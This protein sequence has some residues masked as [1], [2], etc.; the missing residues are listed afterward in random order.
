MLDYTVAATL[1][2][3]LE[4]I[5][6]KA[7]NTEGKPPLHIA[8]SKP[9]ASSSWRR[10][11]RPPPCSRRLPL[12]ISVCHPHLHRHLPS[13]GPTTY[14]HRLFDLRRHDH[15]WTSPSGGHS[16]Q[17]PPTGEH[18]PR[19]L[20]HELRLLRDLMEQALQHYALLE[21]VTNDAPS[22]DPGWIRMDSIILNWINNSISADLHKVVQERGCTAVARRATVGSLLSNGSMPH[23]PRLCVA[24][25]APY[26]CCQPPWDPHRHHR[27]TQSV[28]PAGPL[29]FGQVRLPS[30]VLVPSTAP[31]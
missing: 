23:T 11:P 18:H 26:G 27:L 4:A 10:C 29:I 17:C 31:Y 25:G 2:A 15:R 22:T 1:R 24:A 9:P 14:P 30:T 20:L 28:S 3:R 19:L 5:I 12:A 6:K 13:R 21:H 7:K 8:A 16:T